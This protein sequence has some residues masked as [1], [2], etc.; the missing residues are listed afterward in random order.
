L[1]LSDAEFWN[2]HPEQFGALMERHGETV[3]RS[4]APMAQLAAL[5]V[6]SHLKEGAEPVSPSAFIPGEY[7]EEASGVAPELQPAIFRKWAEAQNKHHG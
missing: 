7:E 1:G 2:L 4:F 5:Y 3:K 6:N